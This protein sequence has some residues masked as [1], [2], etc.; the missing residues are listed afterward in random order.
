VH[1]SFVVVLSVA[2][3][4]HFIQRLREA[5]EAFV[6]RHRSR[7]V[8][9]VDAVTVQWFFVFHRA[10]HSPGDTEGTLTHIM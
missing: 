3:R 1:S 4:C 2:E 6:R 9:D 5:P 8:A 7:E 10:S